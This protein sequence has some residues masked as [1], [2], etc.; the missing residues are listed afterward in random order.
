MWISN[1][2]QLAPQHR[3][4]REDVGASVKPR[5]ELH[6]LQLDP[7]LGKDLQTLVQEI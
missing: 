2:A 6:V 5:V 3:E 4:V 7:P 1:K